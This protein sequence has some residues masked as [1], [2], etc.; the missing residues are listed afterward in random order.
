M[1]RILI[2]CL[3]VFSGWFNGVFKTWWWPVL[4][5]LF[6]PHTMLW[7]SAVMNWYGG[8]WE[9]LQIFILVLSILLH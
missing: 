7:Y 5:F 3:W 8:R 9:F 2:L 1:P 6:M 4:G